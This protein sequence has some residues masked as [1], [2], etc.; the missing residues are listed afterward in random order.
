MRKE[1]RIMV[2][3]LIALSPYVII[4]NPL[5]AQQLTEY[6]RY[7]KVVPGRKSSCGVS[8]LYIASSLMGMHPN[9][10]DL[11]KISQLSLNGTSMLQL[12]T[13]AEAIG[14]TA[15]GYKYTE[16]NW[17]QLRPL[18]IVHIKNKHYLLV[19]HVNER[20][21][22][23]LDPPNSKLFLTGPEFKKMW[24][25]HALELSRTPLSKSQVSQREKNSSDIQYLDVVI[26]P[27]SPSRFEAELQFDNLLAE[28]TYDFQIRVRNSLESPLRFDHCFSSCGCTTVTPDSKVI[29][30]STVGTLR[31]KLS[32]VNST[33]KFMSNV[34]VVFESKATKRT[35]HI[36]LKANILT[37]GLLRAYPP[38]IVYRTSIGLPLETQKLILRRDSAQPLRLKSVATKDSWLTCNR[39]E[40]TAQINN[41]STAQFSV[42]CDSAL[43]IGR[44]ETFIIFKTDHEKFPEIQVPVVVEVNRD[45]VSEPE[46][47][48]RVVSVNSRSHKVKLRLISR[49]G[50]KFT[51]VSAKMEPTSLG[52]VKI[53]NGISNGFA[54]LDVSLSP[55]LVRTE[56]LRGRVVV[57]LK[58]PTCSE[59]SI[60]I[61]LNIVGEKGISAETAK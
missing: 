52:R 17:R 12:K 55:S 57:D 28:K 19:L 48:V 22:S 10:N 30:P 39:R 8:C 32:T 29:Q 40:Y 54:A 27:S 3:L 47:I 18:T 11:A 37:V 46:K 16:K 24:S 6:S 15:K 43:S 42:K 21:L 2:I 35:I 44:H 59:F 20:G 49:S 60:P 34:I 31:G 51:I 1:F 26:L 53:Q 33:G 41:L 4:R 9:L 7:D 50:K 13:A 45:I 25:G 5:L 61:L 58:H 14:L 56:V 36:K 23:V 38:K